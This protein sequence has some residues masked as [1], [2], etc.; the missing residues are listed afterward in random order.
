VSSRL[1]I[2]PLASLLLLPIKAGHSLVGVVD[3]RCAG[4]AMRGE[5]SYAAEYS[6]YPTEE[7]NTHNLNA[8]CPSYAS[9]KLG[10]PEA[11]L[12]SATPRASSSG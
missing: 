5:S 10:N 11:H 3:S 8:T 2:L 1:H 7:S 12:T 9:L 6:S 4:R